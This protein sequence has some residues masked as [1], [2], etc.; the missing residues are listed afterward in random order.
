MV[1]AIQPIEKAIETLKAQRDY[2]EIIFTTPDGKVFDQREA[3]SLSMYTNIIILCG[4]L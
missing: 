2:D 3:N 1:M 4:A